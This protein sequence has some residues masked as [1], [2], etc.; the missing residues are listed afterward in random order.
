[1]KRECVMVMRTDEKGVTFYERQCNAAVSDE[2]KNHC[3]YLMKSYKFH[4]ECRI[5]HA[6]F[7]VY[8]N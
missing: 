7:S 6:V 5:E 8:K 1:M 4:S 2:V 3:K